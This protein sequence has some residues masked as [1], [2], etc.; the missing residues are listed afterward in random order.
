MDT[1]GYKWIQ[2]DTNG[3]K[4]TQKD[5]KIRIRLKAV[6][7]C[8]HDKKVTKLTKRERLQQHQR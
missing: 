7:L 1:K 4:W 8:R 5:T 3:Y 6:A 2:M